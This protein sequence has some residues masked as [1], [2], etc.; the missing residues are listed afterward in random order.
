MF[1]TQ[2]PTAIFFMFSI[3]VEDSSSG[4]QISRF[5]RK[6]LDENCH[7]FDPDKLFLQPGK[8]YWLI[9]QISTRIDCF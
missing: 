2:I 7:Y 4:S 6:D 8:F 3:S 5:F 9:P 1:I